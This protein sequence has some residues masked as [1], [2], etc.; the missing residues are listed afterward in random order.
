MKYTLE[1]KFD[2]IFYFELDEG[3]LTLTYDMECKDIRHE[4]Y[5][6]KPIF[7]ILTPN[8]TEEQVNEYVEHIKKLLPETKVTVI[9]QEQKED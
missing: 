5:T 9:K 1:I 7:K 6:L 2:T 4:R 3:Y 8:I